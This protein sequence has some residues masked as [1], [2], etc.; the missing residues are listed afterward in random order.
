MT[1]ANTLFA[2][3]AA[4]GF[5]ARL[6]RPGCDR[7]LLHRCAQDHIAETW[8]PGTTG[9]AGRTGLALLGQALASLD[10]ITLEAIEHDNTR[11]FL[12]P[13]APVPMW[14]SVWTTEERLLFADCTHAVAAAFTAAGLAPP[15][16]WREPADH[17]AFELAFLATLLTR[18]GQATA[19]G[20]PERARHDVATAAAF[21]AQH[22]DRWARSCLHEINKRA[23][24]DFYRGVALLGIDTLDALQALLACAQDEKK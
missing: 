5:L 20:E 23:D 7:A 21:F 18:A 16:A 6:L 14:E 4:C 8:P 12:G 17:L 1:D 19:E 3:G 2:H 11:L 15:G 22:P 13:E 10:T 24:T 9:E